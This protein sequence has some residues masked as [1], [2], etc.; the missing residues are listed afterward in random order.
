MHEC[1]IAH[2]L[3]RWSI[4]LRHFEAKNAWF[5]TQKL[6]GRHC[7]HVTIM[8]HPSWIDFAIWWETS[9]WI[10]SASHLDSRIV[11]VFLQ[12]INQWLSGDLESEDSPM[13]GIVTMDYPHNS[14]PP[15]TK[16]PPSVDCPFCPE[17]ALPV[18]PHLEV[19]FFWTG[20]WLD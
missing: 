3:P 4:F 17:C 18:D 10:I 7:I 14:K 20:H 5:K 6:V 1:P 11:H 15:G 2:V 16:P 19:I 9:T 8:K 13:K 12:T